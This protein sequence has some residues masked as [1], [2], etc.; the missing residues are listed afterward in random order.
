M[1]IKLAIFGSRTLS[2]ERVE[3]LIQQW[4]NK[5]NPIEIITS[6]ETTGVNEIARIKARENKITLILCYANNEK[7]AQGKYEHRSIEILK[8][9][10]FAL[11]IHDGQSK[12]TKNEIEVAKKMKVNFE[13]IKIDYQDQADDTWKVDDFKWD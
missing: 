2:D 12:G 13:Y 7:Y 11:F 3:N 5:L 4:I 6:G 1:N 10:D 8:R 9:C